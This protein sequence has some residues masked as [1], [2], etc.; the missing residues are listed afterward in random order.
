MTKD[1][2]T[3]G[4][5]VKTEESQKKAKK[6]TRTQLAKL[7][8]N[9]GYRGEKRV[10]ELIQKAGFDVERYPVSGAAGGSF[11][12]DLKLRIKKLRKKVIRRISVKVRQAGFKQLYDW[13]NEPK[14]KY[15]VIRQS[16][17]IR[18]KN[19]Q[20]FLVIL[21][22]QDLL[23]LLEKEKKYYESKKVIKMLQDDK[24]HK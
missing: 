1:K 19:Y 11:S 4:D 22:L 16:S 21:K 7:A 17:L 12:G 15:L 20:D 2:L 24:V 3:G 14:I 10:Q 23:S 9:K 5:D 13:L 8:R 18:K 6:K